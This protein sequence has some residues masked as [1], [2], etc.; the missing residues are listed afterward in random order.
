MKTLTLLCLLLVAVP[1]A[2]SQSR[3]IEPNAKVYIEPMDGF[4]NYLAAAILKKKV[5]VVVVDDRAKAEYVIS[6][7]SHVERAN[8][9]KTMFIS[10]APQAGASISIKDARSGDLVFAYSVDKFNAA[11]ASQSTAEACAK[12][13][14]ESIEKH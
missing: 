7:T 1:F 8:W 14:K 5:P 2:Q 3:H 6:G 4:E 10:G 13:L 11:R 9:A 12:H